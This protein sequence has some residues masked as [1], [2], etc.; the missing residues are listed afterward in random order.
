MGTT[1]ETNNITAASSILYMGENSSSAQ[2]VTGQLDDLRVY[3]NALTATQIKTLMNEGAV[4]F[5]PQTGS[6]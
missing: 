4:R 6:P 3:N 5:G 2:R 1:A